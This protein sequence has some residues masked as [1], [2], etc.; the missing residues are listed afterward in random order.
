MARASHLSPVTSTVQ[1][2]NRRLP[3]LVGLLRRGLAD[4]PWAR[5]SRQGVPSRILAL[6]RQPNVLSPQPTSNGGCYTSITS[7]PF[8]RRAPVKS[9][10]EE[11]RVGKE[12]KIRTSTAQEKKRK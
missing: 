11:R 5:S 10:S 7:I 12:C 1:C 3:G 2:P 4:G 9:R 6:A 8:L